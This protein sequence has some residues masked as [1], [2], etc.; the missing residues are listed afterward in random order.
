MMKVDEVL[1]V[2]HKVQY[3]NMIKEFSI[4]R[5]EDMYQLIIDYP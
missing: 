4:D 5:N 1:L 3:M 2:I